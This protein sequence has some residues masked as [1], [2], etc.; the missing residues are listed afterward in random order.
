MKLLGKP[1]YFIKG[2]KI[3]VGGGGGG[4]RA[5]PGE[6]LGVELISLGPLTKKQFFRS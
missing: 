5:C 6:I 4:G 1:A 3:R 2:E